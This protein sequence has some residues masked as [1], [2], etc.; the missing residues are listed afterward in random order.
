V[1]NCQLTNNAICS[2]PPNVTSNSITMNIYPVP[3]VNAGGNK[4]IKEGNSTIL[5]ATASGN[6]ADITWN[7]ALGLSNNK[8][9]NPTASPT[10]TTTYTLVVQTIDGCLGMDKVT[11]SVF[12]DISIPNTFTPNGDGINDTWNIKYLDSYANCT[13]D[14]YN[15][16]GERVY[17]S[18]GY[19]IPWNGTYKGASLPTGTYYY[20]INL[21]NGLKVL[22]GNVTIIR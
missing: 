19:G 4:A 18:I 2:I 22:S 1:I 17:S 8:I 5:N 10:S 11:V 7:P 12:I 20:I 6:I 16:Y 15:R 14:I 21:K 9:L 13:V 3:I